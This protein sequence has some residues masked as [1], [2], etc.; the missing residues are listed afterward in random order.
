MV[1]SIP[2]TDMNTP[3][4]DAQE[5][6]TYSSFADTDVSLY[7]ISVTTPLLF[8]MDRMEEQ[9]QKDNAHQNR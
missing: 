5:E 9:V 6:C 1:Q 4:M 3:L 8:L 2:N 7:A